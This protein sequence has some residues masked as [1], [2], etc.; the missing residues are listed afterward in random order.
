MGPPLAV[1]RPVCPTAA[2]SARGSASAPPS[3]S[4]ETACPG[5]EWVSGPNA[6]HFARQK[7]RQNSRDSTPANRV[8]RST[9]KDLVPA[10]AK[11][12]GKRSEE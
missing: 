1:A 3:C 8:L 11:A 2:A 5:F 10:Q 7:Q 12:I 4:N 9:L 6:F